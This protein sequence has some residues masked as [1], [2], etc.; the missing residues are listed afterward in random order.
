[1]SYSKQEQIE[2]APE[3]MEGLW[4]WVKTHKKQLVLAGISIS[5]IIGVILGL[6]NKDSIN[7]LWKQLK[8]KI[9][10]ADMYSPNWAKTVAD[11]TL[12]SEREKVRLAFCSPDKELSEKLKLQN[13]LKVIDAEKIKRAWGDKIPQA[14]SFHRE[15]GWY[16]PN[17]D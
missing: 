5:A 8:K 6:K 15:H 17:D 7:A 11:E 13:I 2:N 10:E 16:L 14:P 1:M 4:V 3:N 12:D 9:E